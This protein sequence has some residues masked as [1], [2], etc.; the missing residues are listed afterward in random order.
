MNE[1][2]PSP[3]KTGI[4]PRERLIFALDVADLGQARR[5]VD[6]LGDSVLFYKLGLEFFLSGNY[7]ELAAEL[8]GRGKKLFA[9]LKLF[10]IPATV[11]AAASPPLTLGDLVRAGKRESVLAAIT[12]PDVDVNE[13]APERRCVKVARM[14]V[15]AGASR[16]SRLLPSRPTVL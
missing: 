15:R 6:T 8:Q 7:F 5:L 13:K 11:A 2:T 9:D 12:S 14:S 10:D 4:P 3:I 16:P 1:Q